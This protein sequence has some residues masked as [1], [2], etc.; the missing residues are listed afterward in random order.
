MVVEGNELS[1]EISEVEP[2]RKSIKAVSN[3]LF[4]ILFKKEDDEKIVEKKEEH[5]MFQ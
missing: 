5:M 1:L 2:D 4:D 3:L